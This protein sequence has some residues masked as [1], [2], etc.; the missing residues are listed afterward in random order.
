VIL[1]TS[2]F[3][4]LIVKLISLKLCYCF[5]EDDPCDFL[6]FITFDLHAVFTKNL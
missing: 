5:P 4:L 6:K 2:W 1:K 3:E